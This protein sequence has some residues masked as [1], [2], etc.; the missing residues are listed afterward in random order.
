MPFSDQV[1]DRD[2]AIVEFIG[3]HYG[4]QD[5]HI[6]W[7][8]GYTVGTARQRLRRLVAYKPPGRR[9]ALVEQAVLEYGSGAWYWLTGPGLEWAGLPYK[10]RAL[11]VQNTAHID[12]VLDVYFLLLSRYPGSVWISERRLRHERAMALLADGRQVIGRG[13]GRF[14]D[15]VLVLPDGGR[16]AVEVELSGKARRRRR[17]HIDQLVASGYTAIWYFCSPAVYGGAAMARLEAGLQLAIR[18][19]LD[20]RREVLP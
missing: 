13:L 11:R 16:V 10:Y 12:R 6:A 4:V 20:F 19:G 14:P 3:E 18:Y 17:D 2:R 1:G 8:C 7:F 5:S 9:R 15:G